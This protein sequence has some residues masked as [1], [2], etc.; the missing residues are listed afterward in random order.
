MGDFM[1]CERCGI[2]IPKKTNNQHYCKDCGKIVNVE[3]QKERDKKKKK[4]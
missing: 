3:K 2:L 4:S 1:N